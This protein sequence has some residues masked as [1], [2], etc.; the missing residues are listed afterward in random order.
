[1][2]VFF[3]VFFLSGLNSIFSSFPSRRK[4]LTRGS[5]TIFLPNMLLLRNLLSLSFG[6]NTPLIFH[7]RLRNSLPEATP[8]ARRFTPSAFRWDKYLENSLK[9][10]AVLVFFGTKL[11]KLSWCIWRFVECS[12]IYNFAPT[13]LNILVIFSSLLS[14]FHHHCGSTS[15]IVHL[16]SY[17]PTY[18]FHLLFRLAVY[19]LCSQ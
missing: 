3:R 16:F 17:L 1:M 18:F 12:F 4:Y 6:Y 7:P 15:F 19:P 10:V 11:T 13:C 2:L 5:S 9:N 8:A 14:I